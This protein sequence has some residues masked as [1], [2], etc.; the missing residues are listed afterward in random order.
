MRCRKNVREHLKRSLNAAEPRD[1]FWPG[2]GLRGR[3]LYGDLVLPSLSLNHAA[4]AAPA[5]NAPL[6]LRSPRMSG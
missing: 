4:L 3:Q 5:V 1:G 2:A 6:A